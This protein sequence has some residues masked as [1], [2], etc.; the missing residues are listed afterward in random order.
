MEFLFRL[1]YKLKARIYRSRT[2]KEIDGQTNEQT[3]DKTNKRIRI[4]ETEGGDKLRS[5]R[6]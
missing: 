2:R 3:N 1:G 4:R 6:L 5:R